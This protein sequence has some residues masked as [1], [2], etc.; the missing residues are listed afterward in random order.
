M[1]KLKLQYSGHLMQRTASFE[2]TLVLGKIEGGR[3]RGQQKMRWLDGI[4]DSMHINF[5]KLQELV[6]DREAWNA[7]VHGVTGSWTWLSDWTELA[8][9]VPLISPIFLKRSLVFP[10]LLFSSISM[11]CSF[12]K[13]FLPL[14][15]LL[16]NSAFIG[17]Y[18]SL[19]PLSFTSLLSSAICK[20]SSDNPM[21][22]FISFS[23]GWFRSLPGVQCYELPSIVLQALYLPDKSLDSIH[24]FQYIIIR[25][26]I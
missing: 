2:K 16:L 25:N 15:A 19:A 10:T 9:N 11:H 8:W 24:H 4:I 5:S 1:L 6:M 14:L 26:L 13:S 22:I 18:L 23:W 17:V 20:V 7:A 21:P 3:R 12:K